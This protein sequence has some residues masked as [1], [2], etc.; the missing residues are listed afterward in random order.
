MSE[1]VHLVDFEISPELGGAATGCSGIGMVRMDEWDAAAGWSVLQEEAVWQ[2]VNRDSTGTSRGR[3]L[4]DAVY[5]GVNDQY[6][7]NV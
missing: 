7:R 3:L 1:R 2:A 6:G 5:G 4:Y